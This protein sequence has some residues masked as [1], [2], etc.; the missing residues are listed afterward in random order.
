[1][2]MRPSKRVWVA[3]DACSPTTKRMR[4][5]SRVADDSQYTGPGIDRMNGSVPALSDTRSLPSTPVVPAASMGS[6]PPRGPTQS[7]SPMTQVGH[8]L[9]IC[10]LIASYAIPASSPNM[11]DL[12]TGPR[13][14]FV[15]THQAAA[16]NRH[17]TA[18]T[19]LGRYIALALGTGSITL[20]AYADNAKFCLSLNPSQVIQFVA[21]I[22]G[23]KPYYCLGYADRYIVLRCAIAT[24]DVLLVER[25][26]GVLDPGEC[27]LMVLREATSSIVQLVRNNRLYK[28][29][30]LS[31]LAIGNYLTAHSHNQSGYRNIIRELVERQAAFDYFLAKGFASHAPP[32]WSW[33]MQPKRNIDTFLASTTAWTTDKHRERAVQDFKTTVQ[34]L[35]AA[36]MAARRCENMLH[37]TEPYL[38][39]TSYRHFRKYIQ[40]AD[41]LDRSVSKVQAARAHLGRDPPVK[42][43]PK[44]IQTLGRHLCTVIRENMRCFARNILTRGKS[45]DHAKL[46]VQVINPVAT[47]TD[48]MGTFA[49][50][51][52]EIV[53]KHWLLAP[54]MRQDVEKRVA[55]CLSKYCSPGMVKCTDV[56]VK[57][58]DT[59]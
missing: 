36:L 19:T 55:S 10:R 49:P 47:D 59:S 51:Q 24:Q 32:G 15:A 39:S 21:A 53:V 33:L 50:H 1:M 29:S 17:T 56:T 5:T 4:R 9:P 8:C 37:R 52:V 43:T 57:F 25:M 26:L 42:M 2:S 38:R 14:G 44:F 46:R 12:F 54:D 7:S 28:S 45:A 31:D 58:T 13:S 23:D 18:I 34:F 27:F 6:S 40:V 41:L 20:A 16:T 30:R 3:P 11:I 35:T 48:D 22:L